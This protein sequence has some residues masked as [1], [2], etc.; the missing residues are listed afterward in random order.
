MGARV[1]LSATPTARTYWPSGPHIPMSA[2][3]IE[4]AVIAWSM[5][6]S[7]R[8]AVPASI[9]WAAT[10]LVVPVVAVADDCDGVESVPHEDTKINSATAA[11]PRSPRR[12]CLIA[13]IHLLI[14]QSHGRDVSAPSNANRRD[15]RAIENDA[16]R[17]TAS[18]AFPRDSRSVPTLQ[19][20]G[21][22]RRAGSASHG[23]NPASFGSQRLPAPCYHSTRTHKIDSHSTW[24]SSWGAVISAVAHAD[25]CVNGA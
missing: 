21:S 11:A 4:A 17:A 25:A 14:R 12:H 24:T 10:T 16:R 22:S 2:P 6:A 8:C 3:G 19:D 15:V 18:P 7:S 23:A 1:A 5:A 20:A 13:A 9:S